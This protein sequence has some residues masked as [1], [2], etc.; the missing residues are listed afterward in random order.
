[1][2]DMKPHANLPVLVNC[3]GSGYPYLRIREVAVH[4]RIHPD[5][6]DRFVSLGLID[7][8]NSGGREES[9]LFQREVIP[10]VQK[11]IR[12]RN[13]LGINYSGIGVVLDL[14]DR[15][16]ALEARIREMERRCHDI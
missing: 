15:I 7:P 8:V 6:V 11:I 13:E 9:W 10:L 16:H 2:T 1:M 3:T 12:L 14:L 5:L 4:C